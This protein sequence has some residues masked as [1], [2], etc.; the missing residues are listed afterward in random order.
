MTRKV[1]GLE[2]GGLVVEVR[3]W[4]FREDV[5]MRV[6]IV[7]VVVVVVVVT[8]I[9]YMLSFHSLRPVSKFQ[10]MRGKVG[11]KVGLS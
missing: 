4:E 10:L 5:V 1:G 6:S 2:F 11:R 7:V 9:F 8:L 3:R